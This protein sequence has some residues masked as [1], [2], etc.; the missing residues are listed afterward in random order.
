[1]KEKAIL[2]ATNAAENTINRDGLI[3]TLITSNK[4]IVVNTGSTNGSFHN[5]NGR[6]YGIDQIVGADKI[7]S[8]YIFVKGDGSDGWENVLIVAH[9]RQYNCKYKWKYKYNCN[10]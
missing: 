8:E 2:V 3:G 7:G 4:P 9:L 1:M 6:D 10:Y 5:G